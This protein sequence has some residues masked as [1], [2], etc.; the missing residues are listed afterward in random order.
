LTA[1][2]PPTGLVQNYF[3]L[4]ADKSVTNF[5]KILELKVPHAHNLRLTQG[6]RKSEQNPF[7]ELFNSTM[8]SHTDLADQNPVLTPLA[9]LPR[10]EVTP[11]TRFDTNFGLSSVAER[12]PRQQSVPPE[13]TA[14]G[15]IN[16]GFKN[17]TRNLRRDF[18][19]RGFTREGKD[20]G[21]RTD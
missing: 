18:G 3:F 1:K 7:L 17:L 10:P 4:I 11:V 5:L 2:E 21:G 12:L 9:I 20:S 6:I 15:K 8:S 14:G 16:E 19:L 13:G